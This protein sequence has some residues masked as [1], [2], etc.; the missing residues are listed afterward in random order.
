MGLNLDDTTQAPREF[1]RS[2]RVS[3]A[4]NWNQNMEIWVGGKARQAINNQG[5]SYLFPN[6]QA[7]GGFTILRFS[8]AYPGSNDTA[9]LSNRNAADAWFGRDLEFYSGNNLRFYIKNNGELRVAA[10]GGVGGKVVFDG[11]GGSLESDGSL[12]LQARNGQLS[13]NNGTGSDQNIYMQGNQIYLGYGPPVPGSAVHNRSSLFQEQGGGNVPFGCH[14][15]GNANAAG[16]TWA[17]CPPNEFAISCHCDTSQWG[18]ELK[19]CEVAGAAGPAGLPNGC[20]GAN[21]DSGDNVNVKAMC[22][23]Y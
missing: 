16:E 18:E 6:D 3:P 4:G 22:C 20:R 5:E 7:N 11:A 8:D 14:M 21:E 9:I 15:S 13:I 2:N 10:P 19:A 12:A 17:W 1:I 23:R